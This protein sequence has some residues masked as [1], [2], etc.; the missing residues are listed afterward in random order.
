MRKKIT[1][2]CI[3]QCVWRAFFLPYNKYIEKITLIT[4]IWD[5]HAYVHYYIHPTH[6]SI[7]QVCTSS[8]MCVYMQEYIVK[9]HVI[10]RT[11]F[12]RQMGDTNSESLS[13]RSRTSVS[14]FVL[15][16]G[17]A[18]SPAS[19]YP[20]FDAKIT[21]AYSIF[22]PAFIVFSSHNWRIHK[23]KYILQYILINGGINYWWIMGNY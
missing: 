7:I 2:M 16:L 14:I 3:Q 20:L 18:V 19:L 23:A 1:W 8:H 15:D 17:D 10:Q 11:P 4:I 12:S 22:L 9:S 6:S 21:M 5:M 13:A